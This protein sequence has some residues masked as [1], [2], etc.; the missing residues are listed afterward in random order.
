VITGALPPRVTRGLVVGRPSY[1]LTPLF[2]SFLSS[3]PPLASPPLPPGLP[4]ET[5]RV[6]NKTQ[7]FLQA[8]FYGEQVGA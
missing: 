8:F 5:S 6:L 3:W 1:T 2:S 7:S 4:S